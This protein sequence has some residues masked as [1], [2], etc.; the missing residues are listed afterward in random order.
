MYHY[1]KVDYYIL[2][3]RKIQLLMYLVD[4]QMSENR[5]DANQVG[6]S[7]IATQKTIVGS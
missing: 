5:L 6:K 1:K 2:I 4:I 3:P 7:E